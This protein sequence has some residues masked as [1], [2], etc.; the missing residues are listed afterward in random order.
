MDITIKN[1]DDNI[2]RHGVIKLGSHGLKG[3][4]PSK[5][6]KTETF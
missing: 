4:T 6:N 5:F 2:I 3:K 1:N